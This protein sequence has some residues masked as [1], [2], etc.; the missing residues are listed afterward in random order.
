MMD[1]ARAPPR[2]AADVGALPQ[3]RCPSFP[4]RRALV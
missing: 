1:A 3:D 2:F 4:Y